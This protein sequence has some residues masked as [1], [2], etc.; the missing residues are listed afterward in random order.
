MKTDAKKI[1]KDIDVCKLL[2]IAKRIVIADENYR[3]SHSILHS[4][5]KDNSIA[6]LRILL[7]GKNF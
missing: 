1:L 5:T 7:Q 3:V 4:V 6:D 2:R